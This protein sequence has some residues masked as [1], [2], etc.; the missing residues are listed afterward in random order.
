[1]LRTICKTI[2]TVFIALWSLIASGITVNKDSLRYEILL[3][4]KMLIDFKVNEKF[5]TSLD[6]TSDRLILLSTSN[7]FYLLGWGSITPIGIKVKGNI[8]SYAFT[9]DSVLLTIKNNELC[10][11][12]SLGN[13]SKLYKL[14]NEG[15]G[16]SSGKYVMYIYDRNKEQTNHALYVLARG[17]KYTKLFEVPAP[18]SSVMEMNNLILFA[19]GNAVFSFNLRNKELKAITA[20]PKDKEIKSIAVNSS[21]NLIYL[22]T[23]NSIYALKD[24]N[25]VMITD[26]FGGVLR[27]FD[28]GLIVFNPEKKFLV[29]ILGIEDNLASKMQA[30]KNAM[31][32]KTIVNNFYIIAGS[33]PTEQQANDAIADLKRKGFTEA[34][35]VGKNSYGSYRI[36]YKAY[37]SNSE[38][39]KDITNIKQ[40]INP[41]AWIFERK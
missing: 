17:G 7:Q 5:I 18:I 2:P 13:L 33:Y 29:R 14:P 34:E 40:T 8:S 3:T 23:D 32:R 12:D 24:S 9:S 30:L 20:L 27:Y 38:A 39:A 31:K 22:S 28:E 16:I 21:G 6:I 26:Q 35:V 4:N 37:A 11:F 15:M 41:S 19:T 36:A 25:T 10:N 1:L